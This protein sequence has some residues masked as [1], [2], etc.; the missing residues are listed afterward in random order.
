MP[1]S[2]EIQNYKTHKQVGFFPP[3][4]ERSSCVM[5]CRKVLPGSFVGHST[6][7]QE[8]KQPLMDYIIFKT[9]GIDHNFYEL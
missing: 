8:K 7:V 9:R 6:E 4:R 2:F 1:L 5:F 3:L